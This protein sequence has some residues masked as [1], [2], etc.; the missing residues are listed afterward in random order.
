MQQDSSYAV[1]YLEEELSCEVP[2]GGG[3]GGGERYL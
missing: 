1:R 2:G 3:G